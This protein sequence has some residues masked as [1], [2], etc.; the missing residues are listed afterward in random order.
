MDS[1]SPLASSSRIE[2]LGL[3]FD[4]PIRESAFVDGYVRRSATLAQVF[5]LLGGIFFYVFFL[6]DRII[7]PVGGE[8]THAI[9]GFICTPKKK[10]IEKDTA[11]QHEN[12]RE[13][14]GS[15]HIAINKS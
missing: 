2:R 12:L 13:R 11:Q 7:D 5:M 6:W 14:G 9:R 1:H 15:F 8:L 4:D 10:D 3:G